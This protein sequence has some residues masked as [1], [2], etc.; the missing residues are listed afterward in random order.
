MSEI[1]KRISLIAQN[2][3]FIL[4][5]YSGKFSKWNDLYMYLGFLYNSSV[6][7]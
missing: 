3:I 2:S 7:H 6:A 1:F 4:L 5:K